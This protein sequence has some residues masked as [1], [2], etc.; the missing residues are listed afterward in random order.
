LRTENS[1]EGSVPLRLLCDP[2]IRFNEFARASCDGIE[3]LI[4]VPPNVAAVIN[5]SWPSSDGNVPL[6]CVPAN[7]SERK[8][9]DTFDRNS[10]ESDPDTWELSMCSACSCCEG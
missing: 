1:S 6:S 7:R 5:V 3:P 2:S 9:C 10:A 4:G 8:V